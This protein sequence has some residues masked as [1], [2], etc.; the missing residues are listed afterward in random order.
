MDP[1][2]IIVPLLIWDDGGLEI[3]VDCPSPHGP[4]VERHSSPMGSALHHHSVLFEPLL[5]LSM[6]ELLGDGGVSGSLG[7]LG[8]GA[9][10]GRGGE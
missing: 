3:L 9:G 2:T 8:K 1:T 10:K 4:R 7:P 5:V 6:F